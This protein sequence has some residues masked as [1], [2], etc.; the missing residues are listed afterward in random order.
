MDRAD[1]AASATDSALHLT[2]DTS[3]VNPRKSHAHNSIPRVVASPS[4]PEEGRAQEAVE[5]ENML[6]IKYSS[7]GHHD[8]NPRL[9]AMSDSERALYNS[10]TGMRIPARHHGHVYSQLTPPLS[11]SSGSFDAH[12]PYSTSAH[13][14]STGSPPREQLPDSPGSSAGPFV[15]RRRNSRGL[16]L[17]LQHREED[18]VTQAKIIP[19]N[20]HRASS[21][22]RSPSEVGRSASYAFG[23]SNIPTH[24]H[25]R[26]HTF[27][28]A[29]SY[30]DVP[31][32]PAKLVYTIQVIS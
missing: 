31:D 30:E 18:R 20:L 4:G 7:N 16:Q 10:Q 12:N 13:L 8:R 25:H 32:S 6:S 21:L 27:V 23:T 26:T 17:S 14:Y 22:Y 15:H 11:E 24:H 3:I 5:D 1:S 2:I 9:R 28:D 29:S 19:D